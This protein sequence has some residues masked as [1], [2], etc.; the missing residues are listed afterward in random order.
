VTLE[1]ADGGID[2]AK[3]AASVAGAGLSGGAGS[4]LAVADGGIGQAKLA[5][6]VAGDGLTGGGG[7]ALAVQAGN[8]VAVV[9]DAVAL[10]PL[11]ADW[12]QTGPGD[13]VLANPSSELKLTN[14]GGFATLRSDSFG[15]SQTYRLAGTGGI[16]L[17]QGAGDAAYVNA[18]GDSM[19]GNLSLGAHE[20]AANSVRTSLVRSDFLDLNLTSLSNVRVRIGNSGED[21]RVTTNADPNTPLFRVTT[22]GDVVTDRDLFAGRDLKVDR[23]LV[24]GQNRAGLP[25]S[26]LNGDHIVPIGSTMYVRGNG[27]AITLGSILDG[28]FDNQIL[29]LIGVSSFT[30]TVPDSFSANTRLAADMVL[31]LDDT[32]LLVWAGSDWVEISRSIN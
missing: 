13:I 28:D 3:L 17:T 16:L 10:G 18:A 5:A 2:A 32:L 4:P 1:V 22:L 14:G 6:S 25:A 12:Q 7:S 26:Y 8:G 20:L 27:G 15:S 30:V 23:F 21:F 11:T 9:G 19:T 24:L 31:G 29:L